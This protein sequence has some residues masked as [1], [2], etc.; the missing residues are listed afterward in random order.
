MGL[1][2]IL[3]FWRL[4]G[5]DAEFFIQSTKQISDLLPDAN[6]EEKQDLLRGIQQMWS[7]YYVMEQ[8]YD[9]ALDAGLLLFEMDMYEPSKRY[10]EISIHQEQ[11]E[12]VS[13]VFYCLAICCFELELVE[14]AKGY[15]RKLL[16]LEPDHEEALAL[17]SELELH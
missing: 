7:S 17:I 1:Q 8:R 5:Y 2:Q 15:I 4:G 12:V 11:D 9:L 13:T 6:D 16:E 10:L 3:S 14:A